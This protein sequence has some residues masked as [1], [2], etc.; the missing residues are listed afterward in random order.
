MNKLAIVILHFN[1][2]EDTLECLESIKKLSRDNYDLLNIIV[3]NGSKENFRLEEFSLKNEKIK[4]IRS[5]KNLGFAGG[6]NV[7]IKYALD[8]GASYVLLL[9]NDTVLDKNLIKELLK[10]VQS[11]D[12]V[13]IAVPKIYFAKGFEYHKDKYKEE[14][15]GKVIWYAGGNMDWKNVIGY[16]RGVDEVDHGQ[17]DVAEETDFAT[18]CCMLVRKEAFEKIGLLDEK[19]F[20]YYEDSDFSQRIKNAGYKIV[21]D[22][23]AML[24]HKNAGS[25]GGSG[26]SLQDY[27]I[28][29][30]RLRFGS[31]YASFRT[32][33]SLFRESVSLLVKGRTW[34]KK[35]VLDFYLKRLGKGSY[36]SR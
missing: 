30:N 11:T 35:G 15:L 17:F 2:K 6:N 14:D 8:Q 5:D 19:Y 24:W 16:H 12:Q 26:S 29:R 22:P 32:K 31:E 23:K 13:G 18:G 9:N 25:A 28:T 4:I 3:D 36:I 7:G 21:Y 34:Q 20:L 27:Y 33:L 1:G 10:A